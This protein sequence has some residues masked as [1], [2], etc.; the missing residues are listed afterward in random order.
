LAE[1]GWNDWAAA[2]AAPDFPLPLP[3]GVMMLFRPIPRGEFLMGSR[4]YDSREEPVHRVVIPYDFWLGKFVVTQEEYAAVVGGCSKLGLDPHPS[5][6]KGLRRPVEQVSWDDATAWCTAL[7]Q[8]PGLPSGIREVR[9]PLEAEWEYACRGGTETEYWS[10]DGEEALADVGWFESNSGGQTHDVDTPPQKHPAGLFGLHGNVWEW[11]RDVSDPYA[12]RKRDV[13]WSVRDWTVNDAGADATRYLVPI[14]SGEL[15]D[16]VLRGG[17]WIGTARWCRSAFRDWRRPDVRYRSLGFRVCLVRGPAGKAGKKGAELE[18]AT[19]VGGRG[20]RPQTD[21]AGGG[22]AG[23]GAESIRPEQGFGAA[24]TTGGKP[25]RLDL[26][27]ERFSG[28]AR[29]RRGGTTEGGGGK[30]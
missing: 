21:G 19:G 6:F 16:R 28:K 20:T 3:G 4:G 10:G 12:Y 18:P 27:K 23:V 5:Q 22:G 26:A 29:P 7:Q 1:F 8:W 9:L 13:V 14:K 15:P 25:G 11:C 2:A 24:S 30:A 17:S